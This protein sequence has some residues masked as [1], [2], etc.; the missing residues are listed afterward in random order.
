MVI[1]EELRN[2][3][4]VEG[5]LDELLLADVSVTVDVDGV[6][7]VLHAAGQQ[8]V[9]LLDSSHPGYDEGDVDEDD[10]GDDAS[11]SSGVF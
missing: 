2:K 8:L 9:I 6:P 10:E 4:V 5:V 7:D 1:F 3:L 11:S